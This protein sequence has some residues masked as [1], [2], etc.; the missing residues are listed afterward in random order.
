MAL[1]AFTFVTSVTPG[2]NNFLLLAS[3]AR[4]GVAL[5]LPHIL[6]IQAGCAAQLVLSALGLGLVVLNTPALELALKL[7]GTAYLAYLTWRLCRSNLDHDAASDARPMTFW[8]AVTFQFVNPKT[9]MMTVTAGA[10]MRPEMPSLGGSIAVL[11][12]VFA[13]VGAVS[14]SS[15]V[16]FGAAIKKLLQNRRMLNLFNACMAILMAYTVAT[17]WLA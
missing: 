7:F 6:G 15:W 5:T 11:C 13:L 1:V 8:Q 14:S 3:G 4:F 2:P 17:F 12:T 16:V 10:L 9:W